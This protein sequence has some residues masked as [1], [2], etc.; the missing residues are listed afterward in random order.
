MKKL[1]IMA[2]AAMALT[3]AA[4][5]SKGGSDY[6][7]YNNP[8]Y[9]Y[10]IEVPSWMIQHDP[11]IGAEEGTVFMNNPDNMFDINRI[12]L[13]ASN[14]G[15]VF[16]PWTPEN[17]EKRFVSETEEMSDL[18]SQ[19][20]KDQEFTYTRKSDDGHITIHKAIF[21]DMTM[22]TVTIDYDADMADKLGG[23]V[24]DH[25]LSSLKIK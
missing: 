8:K 17:V 13:Y 7:T 4:C 10:S 14:S 15:Y 16:D 25:I 18:V 5:S 12:D 20:C 3:L 22:A 2:V 1:M 9:G 11:Q 24:A 21:K 23:A 19:E 6:Q